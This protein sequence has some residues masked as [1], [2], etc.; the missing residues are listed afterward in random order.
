MVITL[1]IALVGVLLYVSNLRG[2]F[3]ILTRLVVQLQERVEAL[4]SGALRASGAVQ[5][6][7]TREADKVAPAA[8][9]RPAYIHVPKGV[10]P[11]HPATVPDNVPDIVPD[12]DKD[13]GV[14]EEERDWLGPV[15]ER[16]WTTLRRNAFATVGVGLV[17]LGCSFLFPM[18]V[19]HGF[20][21]PSMR[22]A[23]AAL[24]G[25]GLT[26][27]GLRLVERR[28]DY[29]QV[30]QGGGAAVLYLTVYAAMAF[31]E[32]VPTPLAFGIFAVLSAGVIGLSHRQ[33]AK[34]LAFLGFAG[35][36]LAPVLTVRGTDH[37]GVVLAYG[38]LVNAASLWIG[39]RQRWLEMA[40]QAFVWSLLV[41]LGVYTGGSAPLPLVAQ[42]AFIAGYGLMFALYPVLYDFESIVS[43]EEQLT[44][45][46]M[47]GILTPVVLGLE[48]WVG[49]RLGLC[50]ASLLAASF[51]GWRYFG[52]QKPAQEFQAIH[53]LMAVAS[54]LTAVIAPGLD[55]ALTALL[56]GSVAVAAYLLLPGALRLV[57][58]LP[59]AYALTVGLD[60][61]TAV[62]ATVAAVTVLTMGWV[63]VARRRVVDAWVLH[64]A[65][66]ALVLVATMKSLEQF[67]FGTS[68]AYALAVNGL[69]AA[70]VGL[71]HR[72]EK[73]WSA[74]VCHGLVTCGL[75]AASLL[76]APVDP[77]ASLVQVVAVLGVWLLAAVVAHRE[78][79]PR[80]PELRLA[81]VLS[82]ALAIG[83]LTLQHVPMTHDA[84]NLTALACWI[85]LALALALGLPIVR[86]WVSDC[87][88]ARFVSATA[89][90]GL[91][92]GFVAQWVGAVMFNTRPGWVPMQ[93]VW[94]CVALV[95]LGR[96][97]PMSERRAVVAGGAAL[98]VAYLLAIG[99]AYSVI[100]IAW[101]ATGL[102]A[103]V[104]GSRLGDRTLWLAGASISTVVVAKLILLD[105]SA[106]SPMWR[107]LSF[108][109]SGLIFV[110]AGYLA[111]SPSRERPSGR[112]E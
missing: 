1:V 72:R 89:L 34:P 71:W 112:L 102:F 41:G 64:A 46:L 77:V 19:S 75:T 37:L 28:P 91:A 99:N 65:S 55:S 53:A 48:Y 30:L 100:T 68:V 69:V 32:M 96:E 45:E 2:R 40:A 104:I 107:V 67:A 26:G 81:V 15:A 73:D 84:S 58:A 36:Y 95:V 85:L 82:G 49:G 18:L 76:A 7:A 93:A 17:L 35:A 56:A 80:T 70:S 23:L 61:L 52:G 59:A 51:H 86:N 47:T 39:L 33:V 31:Y 101:A 25:A 5:T 97:R 3:E 24:L 88:D 10:A 105:M 29:A 44:L 98:I 74:L 90:Y 50:V 109:G 63:A 110:L 43:R 108:I 22:I 16:L 11:D 79:L 60:P 13:G 92:F 94:M 6:A 57:A 103:V 9:A 78:T 14:A 66:A 54:L 4:E 21:P 12:T 27:A 8:T 62:A 38:L 87:E 83:A 106:A 42:Q 111:P 20:F